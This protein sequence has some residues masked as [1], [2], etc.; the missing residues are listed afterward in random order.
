MCSANDARCITAFPSHRHEPVEFS[1]L[2][3]QGQEIL[4]RLG[5]RFDIAEDCRPATE[6]RGN[7]VLRD[8]DTAVNIIV[9]IDETIAAERLFE[10]QVR[11]CNLLLHG[12]SEAD[13]GRVLLEI[14]RRQPLRVNDYRNG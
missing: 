5:Q 13:Q 2:L 8:Q 3:P 1:N 10:P 11:C 4:T 14:L 6:R 12:L 9:D 7:K